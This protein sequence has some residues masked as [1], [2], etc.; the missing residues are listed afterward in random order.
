MCRDELRGTLSPGVEVWFPDLHGKKMEVF[1]G[2]CLW[3]F[4]GVQRDKWRFHGIL[5]R[6]GGLMGFSG[7]DLHYGKRRWFDPEKNDGFYQSPWISHCIPL[8]NG[9]FQHWPWRI[10]WWLPSCISHHVSNISRFW[11]VKA[12]FP[13]FVSA[14]SSTIR[15]EHHECSIFYYNCASITLIEN[16]KS[17]VYSYIHQTILK[18]LRNKKCI[19][20][21]DI[22]Y[23]NIIP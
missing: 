9:W 5:L 4:M 8:S 15:G 18:I 22:S 23:Y 21:V 13:S 19:I 17:P 7:M 11:L 10:F 1:H 6:Y 14:V 2:R 12:H 20:V 16:W 3:D